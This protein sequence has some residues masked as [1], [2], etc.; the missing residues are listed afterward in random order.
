MIPL[1]YRSL[2][3]C[4]FILKL[5]IFVPKLLQNFIFQ[6]FHIMDMT[7]E[8]TVLCDKQ[9]WSRKKRSKETLISNKTRTLKLQIP[10]NSISSLTSK[11]SKSTDLHL[12]AKSETSA[13]SS[14]PEK[15]RK[16]G[17]LENFAIFIGKHL[18]RNL[19]LV[20]LQV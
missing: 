4:S 6:R 3:Y 18:C 2:A 12:Q 17:V 7:S 13:R 20:K 1:S 15:F 11:I 14:R 10:L 8:I 19:I 16:N 9:I 5:I